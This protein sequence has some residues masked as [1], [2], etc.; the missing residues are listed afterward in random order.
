MAGLVFM[1][2]AGTAGAQAVLAY[3]DANCGCCSGWI[4]H[5]QASGFEVTAVDA[6]HARMQAIKR[7]A[8]VRAWHA[9]CHTAFVGGYFI[10]GHVPA[11]DVERLLAEQPEAGGLAAPGMPAGSPGMEA[12]GSEPYRVLLVMKDGSARVCASH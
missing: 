11:G 10:E 4:A 12:A 5:M 9:S 7:A 1:L 3:Q 8:G 2:S 6:D